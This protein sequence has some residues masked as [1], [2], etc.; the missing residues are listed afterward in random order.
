MSKTIDER[1]VSMRFDNAD[2]EKNIDKSKKS[3]ESF[4]KTLDESLDTSKFDVS[5]ISG[6]VS[7]LSGNLSGVSSALSTVGGGFTALQAIAFGA[8]Q[9]IGSQVIELGEKMVKELA[10]DQVTQ[11][12]EK[13]AEKTSSVQTIMAATADEFDN[14]ADQME[15]VSEQLEKLNWFTDETSYNFVDMT[16]NIGKFTSQGIKLDKAVTAME[17]ISTWAAQSG[18]NANEASRAMYNLSQAL[19]VGAVKLQDWKSIEN[20]NMATKE[21]KEM[22]IAAGIANGTIK[23]GQVTIQNFSQSLSDKGTN[24]WFTSDVLLEVLQQYGSFTDALNEACNEL[25]TTAT[26]LLQDLEDYGDGALD[27][28]KK[29]DEY[30]VSAERLKEILDKLGDSEYDLG[31]KSFKSAQE[32]K[33]FEEAIEATK[34]AVSTS[35]LNIFETIFGN[36]LEAKE[37]W[38]GLANY[39]YDVFAEPVNE[40][41]ELMSEW[42]DR[43]G[44]D[45]LIQFFSNMG[46][47]ITNVIGVIKDAWASVFGKIST[48]DLVGITKNLNMMSRKVKSLTGNASRFKTILVG[49][50][51]SFSI[52]IKKVKVMY[53]IT[54][55]LR[56]LL[57]KIAIKLIDV[58]AA[59]AEFVTGIN[60][61]MKLTKLIDSEFNNFVNTLENGFDIL[62]KFVE[63]IGKAFEIGRKNGGM[64]G[65]ISSSITFILS[66]LK[67]LSEKTL[68]YAS[69]ITGLDF[70]KFKDSVSNSFDETIRKWQNLCTA[71]KKWY[72]EAG[73]GFKGVASVIKNTILAAFT[74]VFTKIQEIT[75]IDFSKVAKNITAAFNKV[76]SMI[77]GFI[78]KITGID[79]ANEQLSTMEWIL[80]I[81]SVTI[82]GLIDSSKQLI[83]TLAKGVSE[84][85]LLALFTLF[86]VSDA[87]NFNDIVKSIS[88]SLNNLTSKKQM[89][90]MKNFSKVVEESVGKVTDSVD[91]MT[92]TLNP[93]NIALV[94]GSL[95]MLAFAMASL[96][97]VDATSIAASVGAVGGLFGEISA[98]VGAFGKMPGNEISSALGKASLAMIAISSAVYIL[99]KAMIQLQGC[100]LTDIALQVGAVVSSIASLT[101]DIIGLAYA[102]EGV[103]TGVLAKILIV[104]VAMI[105]I[106]KSVVTM[107][108]AITELKNAGDIKQVA[109]SVIALGIALAALTAAAVVLSEYGPLAVFG[110]IGMV[111][112]AEAVKK[113]VESISVLGEMP[114]D[115]IIRGLAAVIALLFGLVLAIKQLTLFMGNAIGASIAM[116]ALAYSVNLLV[117]PLLELSKLNVGQAALGVATLS[118]TL[119]AFSKAVKRMSKISLGA[120]IGVLLIAAGIKIIANAI[121]QISELNG[122]KVAGSLAAIGVIL[123]EITKAATKMKKALKGAAALFIAAEGV[124]VI[125]NALNKM[126]TITSDSMKNSLLGLTVVIAE[127]VIACKA[128][129]KCIGG[130]IAFGILSVS[131]QSLALALKILSTVNFEDALQGLAALAVALAGFS[132]LSLLLLPFIPTLVAFSLAL[133]LCVAAISAGLMIS[134]KTFEIFA[135]G[136]AIFAVSG[137]AAAEGF[138][139][140]GAAMDEYLPVMTAFIAASGP[141]TLA[142]MAVGIACVV[143]GVGLAAF[144]VGMIIIGVGSAVLGFASRILSQFSE[145]AKIAAET[146]VTFAAT[147]AKSYK[148]IG[149]FVVEAIGLAVAIIAVSAASYALAAAFAV[150]AI[151]TLALSGAFAIVCASI[152]KAGSGFEKIGNSFKQME[153]H[154][155]PAA[156][157]I[158]KFAEGFAL[159]SPK[160]ASSL[161]DLKPMPK[162][163]EELS[164]SC[165]NVTDSVETLGTTTQISAY[166]MIQDLKNLLSTEIDLNPVI[167]PVIDTS[168]IDEG[169]T[170]INNLLT[171]AANKVNNSMA[172]YVDAQGNIITVKV[173]QKDVIK[174][175]GDLRKDVNMLGNKVNS[176]KVYMNTNALVGQIAP[177]MDRA[178]GLRAL[179]NARAN[180]KPTIVRKGY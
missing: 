164:K 38:T 97:S 52:L 88:G 153:Q 71:L 65:G 84:S 69:E 32:A 15:Y 87:K 12:F 50:F 54:K 62:V 133:G 132:G 27:A 123:L 128:M 105:L 175:L 1:I 99:T 70:S 85:P 174:T 114:T 165:K 148:E 14:Q 94:A 162:L 76:K 3:L 118:A 142:L 146:I 135:K 167:T 20:A 138:K 59:I 107:A 121:Q 176:L 89:P 156:E 64:L 24:G 73:G 96:A 11:G 106:A 127:L 159:A 57:I 90:D 34:D 36:Y 31:R 172:A 51:S 117:E 122:V 145:H 109:T 13:Y 58:A 158:G 47:A 126:K 161:K 92:K 7:G 81:I 77:S 72:E 137:S 46:E 95:A 66:S 75:G 103:T 60:R 23:E 151:P 91:S 55:P 111:I 10:I 61:G 157:A 152:D 112:L 17:G 178:L 45:N 163:L 68:D 19:G 48:K 169:V 4:S 18:A 173:D 39:L 177:A 144:G 139:V 171:E 29:A 42:A 80:E 130:A 104:S 147:M 116:L 8:L 120:G 113:L 168:K 6:K 100:N 108:K 56:D 43:G 124:K 179:R 30:G 82:S 125:A 166:N 129:K 49:I 25:D 141:L 115:Q 9:K 134:A 101:G 2:F 78:S 22:A 143:A 35:W 136:L 79:I 41:G 40:I 26:E 21:F 154:G 160:I 149:I 140:L 119:T 44:R 131:V 67:T 37:L 74:S 63:G 83:S 170:K 110:A 28:A 16:N 180:G 53:K 150:L 102:L 98:I 33:T 5:G 93:V 155:A 86:A